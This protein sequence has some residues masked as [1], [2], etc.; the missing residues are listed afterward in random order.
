LRRE[1]K[2]KKLLMFT[3]RRI[4][5]TRVGVQIF[6]TISVIGAAWLLRQTQ[7]AAI[8]ELFYWLVR[9]F[10]GESA[11]VVDKRLSNARIVELEQKVVE[12]EKQNQQLKRLLGYFEK[13]KQSAI[14]APIIGRSADGWWQQVILGRGSQEGI[15]VGYA[16]T[17]V[18]GL[19]GRVI[20]VTPHTSRVRLISDPKSRVGATVTRSRAMGLIKGRSDRI[21]V[22]EFFEKVP[23]IRVGDTITTSAVSQLFPSGLPIGRVQSL[24]LEKGPA[25]EAKIILSAP[26]D[27]LEWAVVHPFQNSLET[28]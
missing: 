22:M 21:A 27:D 7:G 2:R 12:L 9:P 10:Q 25:P 5:W 16:V 26:V 17:G 15:K 24:N 3:V 1:I 4:K 6:L 8:Q 28:K 13:N 11:S 19:V 23:D 18:G 20:E 14:T